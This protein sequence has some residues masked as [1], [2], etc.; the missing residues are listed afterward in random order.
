MSTNQSIYDNLYSSSPELTSPYHGKLDTSD[1]ITRST[2]AYTTQGEFDDELNYCRD[3]KPL[4]TA[5]IKYP[6]PIQAFDNDM[7][8]LSHPSSSTVP[9]FDTGDFTD[10]LDEDWMKDILADAYP[11]SSEQF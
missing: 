2:D 9:T 3:L 6:L 1:H 10:E 5:T 11:E 4:I 8:P 7:F